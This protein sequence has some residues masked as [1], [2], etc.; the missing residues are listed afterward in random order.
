M[1][2]HQ[3]DNSLTNYKFDI[4]F[5]TDTVWEYHFHKN[6]ELIYV[7]KG[8]LNCNVNGVSYRLNSEDFGMCLPY[9]IHRLEPEKDTLYWVL[10]FSEDY[11]RLFSKQIFSKSGDGF[12]FRCN[13]A[14]ETFVK[15]LTGRD[16]VDLEEYAKLF[17]EKKDDF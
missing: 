14:V 4:S 5:Y 16:E 17:V 6:I 12:S 1:I 7:L 9:D 8:A 15:Y 13:K 3:P 10:V 11:V 2:F